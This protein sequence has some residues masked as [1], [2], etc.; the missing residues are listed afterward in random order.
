MHAAFQT[1]GTVFVEEDALNVMQNNNNKVSQ[2]L[3]VCLERSCVSPFFSQS[4]RLVR[5]L[6]RYPYSPVCNRMH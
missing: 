4:Q 6:L 1:A 3:C 2:L 5:T